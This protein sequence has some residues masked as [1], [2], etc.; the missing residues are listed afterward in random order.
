[1]NQYYIRA[2]IQ[3]TFAVLNFVGND[4]RLAVNGFMRQVG[5][6]QSGQKLQLLELNLEGKLSDAY[7]LKIIDS[8][9]G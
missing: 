8:K 5:Y 1:M 6:L 2:I 3:D 7:R 9:E 4:R